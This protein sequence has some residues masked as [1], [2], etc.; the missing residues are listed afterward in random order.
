MYKFTEKSLL[1]FA[2]G[3]AG[4]S[5]DALQYKTKLSQ[6]RAALNVIVHGWKPV[7]VLASA[8]PKSCNNKN[9]HYLKSTGFIWFQLHTSNTGKVSQQRDKIKGLIKAPYK[10]W[11]KEDW[12]RTGKIRLR[13]LFLWHRSCFILEELRFNQFS[14]FL[15]ISLAC[16]YI[17]CTL[18][19]VITQLTNRITTVNEWISVCACVYVGG[20]R[21]GK[22]NPKMGV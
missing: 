10:N 20:H 21:S 14:C 11:W 7:L 3:R 1:R 4:L 9:R 16:D 12:Y 17:F 8:K 6:L 18:I 15:H 5:L 2:S 22:C 19:M 13:C